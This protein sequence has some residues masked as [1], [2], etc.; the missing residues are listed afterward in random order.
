[1]TQTARQRCPASCLLRVGA[2]WARPGARS[3]IN[4]C[5]AQHASVRR[6]FR[7]FIVGLYIY[8]CERCNEHTDQSRQTARPESEC[9]AAQLWG[10]SIVMEIEARIHTEDVSSFSERTFCSADAVRPLI[11][12]RP[13]LSSTHSYGICV[14]VLK[15]SPRINWTQRKDWAPTLSPYVTN[16][17]ALF[18]QYALHKS[19]LAEWRCCQLHFLSIL[20]PFNF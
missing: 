3:E 14:N 5:H 15:V 12:Y 16:T 20:L 13:S 17:I 10:N 8:E 6:L 1:M 11:E 2:R 18:Q 7:L 19:R 4:Y 9:G